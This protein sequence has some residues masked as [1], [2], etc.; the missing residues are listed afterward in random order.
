MSTFD[1]IV[2][3]FCRKASTRLAPV[4]ELGGRSVACA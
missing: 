1:R 4:T 3:A 2:A